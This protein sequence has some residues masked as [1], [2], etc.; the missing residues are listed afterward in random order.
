[1]NCVFEKILLLLFV[2]SNFSSL[3]VYSLDVFSQEPPN[4]RY[5]SPFPPKERDLCQIKV[6]EDPFKTF[7][8]NKDNTCPLK[9]SRGLK[10]PQ[11]INEFIFKCT[12]NF[13]SA[14]IGGLSGLYYDEETN[15]LYAITDENG[16]FKKQSYDPKETNNRPKT[17]K[18]Q[19]DKNSKNEWT[20]K[21][22]NMNFIYAGDKPVPPN[23]I[24]IEAISRPNPK[25]D[26]YIV[27]SEPPRN[28]DK[29]NNLD[30]LIVMKMNR[31]N[32]IVIGYEIPEEF[33]PTVCESL[34]RSQKCNKGFKSNLCFEACTC[35]ELNGHLFLVAINEKPLHQDEK[36]FK[37]DIL[38]FSTF[39]LKD[40]FPY[41][42]AT[43]VTSYPYS[44]YKVD[45]QDYIVDKEFSIP[46]YNFGV[47]EV[48][49]ISDTRFWVVERSHFRY[50]L[51]DEIEA[52]DR[53]VIRIY[54]VDLDKN[55]SSSNLCNDSAFNKL[56]N[57]VLLEKDL[58][59]ELNEQNIN[60]EGL[61]LGPCSDGKLLLIMVSD[62]NFDC[63]KDVHT[64]FLFY[65]INDMSCVPG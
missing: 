32:Q 47:S 31:E 22:I 18:F 21:P 11:F 6:T 30:K 27:C 24:D 40:D 12:D 13:D 45:P 7:S 50:L 25:A 53:T 51:K 62:N 1:M 17:F 20:L 9:F 15:M 28:L 14:T 19:L 5:L 29:A 4:E 3:D 49:K 63:Q 56:S 16:A 38:R 59:L 26:F 33:L 65:E 39:S 55:R 43:C 41:G 60:I 52:K 42:K 23:M 37:E 2:I 57:P 46:S 54:E 8:L 64:H 44:F 36:R 35:Y 10:K 48:L 61:T 34:G 58:I